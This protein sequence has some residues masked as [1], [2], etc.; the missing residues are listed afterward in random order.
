MYRVEIDAR[1]CSGTSNCIEDAPLAFEMGPDGIARL[2][3]GASD[4]D[5]LIGARVCPLDAIRVIDPQ[6]GKRLHP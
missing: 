3:P 2:L 5:L 4:E 6:T 1:L